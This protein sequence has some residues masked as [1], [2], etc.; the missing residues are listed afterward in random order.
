MRAV[1]QRV[2]R[3]SVTVDGKSI[4]SIGKGLLVLVGVAGGDAEADAE[5]LAEKVANLRIFADADH[6]MN[7]GLEDSADWYQKN[8]ECVS[9]IDGPTGKAVLQFTL[10]A[11]QSA[12]TGREVRPDDV[13]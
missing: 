13:K 1:V 12:A 9:L 7:L 11:L 3:A 10:A 8:H 2:K 5:F 6:K 4:A